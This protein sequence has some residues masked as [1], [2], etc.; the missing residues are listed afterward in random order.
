MGRGS[1]IVEIAAQ[2][3]TFLG[4]SM[5]CGQTDVGKAGQGVRNKLAA[6]RGRDVRMFGIRCRSGQRH[7]GS[8]G[9]L[10]GKIGVV[11]TERLPLWPPCEHQNAGGYAGP[12]ENDHKRRAGI[13]PPGH[14]GVGKPGQ[15][16]TAALNRRGELVAECLRQER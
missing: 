7:S 16:R 10:A 12:W 15:L 14:Q 3:Q 5:R 8:G 2:L 6:Q 1:G 13:F 4:W 9:E 11:R